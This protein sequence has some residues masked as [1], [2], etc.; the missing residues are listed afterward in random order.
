MENIAY[1]VVG[2]VVIGLLVWA[3]WRR[4]ENPFSD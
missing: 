2:L 1:I 4:N 3:V